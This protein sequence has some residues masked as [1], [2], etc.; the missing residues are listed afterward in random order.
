MLAKFLADKHNANL[1]NILV[2]LQ[3]L[4]AQRGNKSGLTT[5]QRLSIQSVAISA[6]MGKKLK[7]EF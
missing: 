5:S 2:H 6:T 7:V 1:M 4:F 3:L